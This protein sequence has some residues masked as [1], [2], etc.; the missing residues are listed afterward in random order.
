MLVGGSFIDDVKTTMPVAQ[1]LARN[2]PRRHNR[3]L[4]EPERVHIADA[5][6]VGCQQR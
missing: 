4:L 6:R 5:G 1:T 3:V 2:R